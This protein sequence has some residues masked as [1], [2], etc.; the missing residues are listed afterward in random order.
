M[1]RIRQ[2]NTALRVGGFEPITTDKRI[3][4][5]VRYV[6]NQAV[7]VV[8]NL[9]SD[10]QKLKLNFTGSRLE[11]ARGTVQELTLNKTLATL[12]DANISSYELKLNGAGLVLLEVQAQ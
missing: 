1:I 8:I 11:K 5:F 9:D 2:A 3:M 12:S 4:A 6:D 7:I 10:P